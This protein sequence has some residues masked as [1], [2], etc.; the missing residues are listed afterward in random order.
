MKPVKVRGKQGRYH[1]GDLRRVLVSAALD[2]V[3]EGG[4]EAL[5]LRAA[6]RR[7]EVSPAAPYRHFPDKSALLAAVAEL[8]FQSLRTALEGAR[9]EDALES[10]SN[11]GVAYVSFALAHPGQVRVMFGPEV[12]DK[13]QHPTLHESSAASFQSLVDTISAAQDGGWVRRGPPESFA[14]VLWAAMHGLASLALSD[15]LDTTD[16]D[17][18]E[19]ARQLVGPTLFMGLR[20]AD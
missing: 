17:P 10:L 9:G 8:G 13:A 4:V 14:T 3:N 19:L 2:L 15:Q 20:N 11:Q 1:H 16:T 18:A 12:S 6:A 5:T 7:A